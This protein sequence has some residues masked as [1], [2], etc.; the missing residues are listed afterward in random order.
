MNPGAH[1]KHQQN[2]YNH[3]KY[4]FLLLKICVENTCSYVRILVYIQVKLLNKASI[5]D[6]PAMPMLVYLHMEFPAWSLHTYNSE[7]FHIIIENNWLSHM[8]CWE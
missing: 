6:S 3:S 8:Q 5:G 4:I 7:A 1:Y 2:Y